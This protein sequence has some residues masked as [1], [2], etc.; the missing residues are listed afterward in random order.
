MRQSYTEVLPQIK[1]TV[2]SIHC[3]ACWNLLFNNINR[4]AIANGTGLMACQCGTMD[5]CN[6][7]R[8]SEFDE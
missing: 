4:P 6:E 5:S 7:T 8:L 3:Q 1:V 2:L